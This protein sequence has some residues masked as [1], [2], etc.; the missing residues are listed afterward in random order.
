MDQN[1]NARREQ[2][3]PGLA[4]L[5]VELV[6]PENEVVSTQV[7]DRLGRYRFDVQSGVRTNHYEIRITKDR[8]GTPLPR[9]AVQVVD[10]TR[11]G[12]TVRAD[13]PIGRP[14]PPTPSPTQNPAQ[15]RNGAPPIQSLGQNPFDQVF[16]Q[17]GA[18]R[19]ST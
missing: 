3:E 16:A 14:A 12:Q 2:R 11:G 4:G 13:F 19:R 7:T 9:T 10:I 15:Q 6:T 1:R 5:T 8:Q 18:Q 17:L